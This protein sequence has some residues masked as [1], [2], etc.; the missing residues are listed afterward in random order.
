MRIVK[1]FSGFV[2]FAGVVVAFL[3]AA[4]VRGGACFALAGIAAGLL[5][6]GG[7]P[8]TIA[9]RLEERATDE[10]AEEL[11]EQIERETNE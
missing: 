5:L 1:G 2:L 7:I 11:R 6:C 9:A 10:N 8:Y 3:A 4:A